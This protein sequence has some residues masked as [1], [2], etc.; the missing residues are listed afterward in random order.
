MA[1]APRLL[2]RLA[3]VLAVPAASGAV[4]VATLYAADSGLN[5]PWSLVAPVAAGVLAA[6]LALAWPPLRRLGLALEAGASLDDSDRAAAVQLGLRLP[7]RMALTVTVLA[8]CT[9]A[10]VVLFRLSQGLSVEATLVAGAG[11]F[12]FAVMAAMLAYS[13]LS[14]AVAP[15]L[16]VLGPAPFTRASSIR[17]K[18]LVTAAG[19]LAFASLL[20]WPLAYARY[21][22]D[23]DQHEIMHARQALRQAARVAVERG[24]KA[25]AEFVW[26]AAEASAVVLSPQGQRVAAAGEEVPVGPEDASGPELEPTAGGWRLREPLGNGQVLLAMV[27]EAPLVER[28]RT[29][30]GS[31]SA[32]GVGLLAAAI[33]LAVAVAR[34]FAQPLRRLGRSAERVAAGDLTGLT[35]AVTRDEVGQLAAD[36]LHMTERLAALVRSVQEASRGVLDGAREMEAIGERVRAGAAEE[37]AQVSGVQVAVEAMQDSVAVAGRGV[38]SLSEYVATTGAAVAEMSAA[39]GEVRRQATELERVAEGAGLDVQRLGDVRLR[40]QAQL[41]SME[42]LATATGRS[43]AAVSTSLEGLENSSVASQLAAAQAAELAEHA[44]VVVR[45]AAD[46]IEGVRTAVGDAKRRVFALGR[47]SDD[48]DQILTFIGEVAGRTS[49]LSLNASIIATQAGEHGKAFTVVAEQIRELAA[50]ISVSTRS[51][52]EII[53]AVRQDVEGTARVIDEGDGLAAHGVALARKSLSALDEIRTA[54]ARGHETAAAIQGALLAHADS[55]REVSA[56]VA[57]VSKSSQEMAG[58][59][60]TIGRS[61]SAIASVTTGVAVLADRV[62]SALDEQSDLGRRQMESLEHINAMVREVSQAM[63]R[64]REST[65]SVLESLRRLA[66][67]AQQHDGAVGALGGLGRRLSGHSQALAERVGRFKVS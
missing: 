34:G 44:G 19:L 37:R 63:Q 13:I 22:S 36:F 62:S 21:R 59:L 16:A 43:V 24:P 11:A 65:A 4:L 45:E 56:L 50:Q 2:L 31:G 29:F 48:I 53:R 60:T 39:L 41:S 26:M 28:R 14:T 20:T 32:L 1:F 15:A 55:T 64:H 30:V 52:G 10:G 40:A 49:L 12:A 9:I 51:I 8:I 3:L 5:P 47:R 25:A 66:R 42:E 6:T 61:A 67:T 54:T 23:L 17:S 18:A 33:L 58:A 57:Q 7:G 27:P 46:G 38:S 35:P